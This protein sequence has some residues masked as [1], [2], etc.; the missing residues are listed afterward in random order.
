MPALLCAT[1]LIDCR[2]RQDYEQYEAESKLKSQLHDGNV[3]EYLMEK[4]EWTTCTF[5]SVTWDVYGTAFRR[6]KAC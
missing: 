2:R 5:E 6:S 1:H 3:K 4:E